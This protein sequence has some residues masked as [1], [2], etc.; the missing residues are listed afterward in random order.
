MAYQF[1]RDIDLPDLI[2][3]A[4]S[5]INRG[6]Y[7]TWKC[8][9]IEV[10]MPKEIN[11]SILFVTKPQLVPIITATVGAEGGTNT[12]LQTGTDTQVTAATTTDNST[13]T[14]DHGETTTTTDGDQTEYEAGSSTNS[15]FPSMD[16]YLGLQS[17]PFPI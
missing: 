8:D 9:G 7:D 12:T 16:G 1:V 11:F 6:L 2:R 3:L 13:Q 15:T 5:R 4:V 14:T 17:Q 10:F